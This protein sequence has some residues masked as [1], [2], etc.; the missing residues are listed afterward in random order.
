MIKRTRF[1]L[2]FEN[3]YVCIEFGWIRQLKKLTEKTF[4]CIFLDFLS[5]FGNASLPKKTKQ[6]SPILKS[7]VWIFYSFSSWS[8]IIRRLIW[9]LLKTK[10]YN[11][12]KVTKRFSQWKL[13]LLYNVESIKLKP[14]QSFYWKYFSTD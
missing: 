11:G 5:A 1:N 3:F 8:S 10:Y 9:S 14:R 6:K 2:K 4:V 12:K 7:A 13:F